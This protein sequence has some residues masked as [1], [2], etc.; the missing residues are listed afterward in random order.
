MLLDLLT[1]GENTVIECLSISPGM[2]RGNCG[3]EVRLGVFQRTYNLRSIQ[4]VTLMVVQLG[5]RLQTTILI[6]GVAVKR[7]HSLGTRNVVGHLVVGTE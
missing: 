3:H 1:C 5:C 4:A 7:T 6:V 2:L